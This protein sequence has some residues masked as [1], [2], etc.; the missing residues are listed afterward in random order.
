MHKVHSMVNYKLARQRL[1]A[2]L[3]SRKYPSAIVDDL[4]ANVATFAISEPSL[5][6]VQKRNTLYK[7]NLFHLDYIFVF[8][9]AIASNVQTSSMK[10]ETDTKA[11]MTLI[12]SLIGVARIAGQLDIVQVLD[13]IRPTSILHDLEYQNGQYNI[14]KL[15]Q[16]KACAKGSCT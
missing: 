14:S 2:F 15:L 3:N 8:L 1:E 10:K 16:A 6:I 9:I 11:L 7:Q 5:E 13:T 12:N 4:V